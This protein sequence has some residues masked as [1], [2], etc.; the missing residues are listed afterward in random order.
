MSHFPLNPASINDEIKLN[1]NNNFKKTIKSKQNVT[2]KISSLNSIMTNIHNKTD[3]DEIDDDNFLNKKNLLINEEEFNKAANQDLK[4]DK[5]ININ[6]PNIGSLNYEIPK[7]YVDN[8]NLS[9]YDKSYNSNFY[10]R[11]MSN[12]ENNKIN[13]ISNKQLLDKLNYAIHL[14]EEQHNEK[15][16]YITEELILY[17][18]L[19]IFIIFVLDTFTKASKYIR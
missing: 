17:L 9:N 3:D 1:Q 18:F 12:N 16:N 15:T 5:N 10:N 11:T 8:N 4:L 14:L 19:G 13:D 2:P 6:K 7:S